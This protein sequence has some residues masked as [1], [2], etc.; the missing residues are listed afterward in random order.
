MV[1][2][3]SRRRCGTGAALLAAAETEIR[4]AGRTCTVGAGLKAG[5]PGAAW[6]AALGF[7]ETERMVM[8]VVRPGETDPALWESDTPPG[9]RI[10][11]WP[12]P[13][14]EELVDS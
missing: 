7:R 2:H 3:P 12:G 4:A 5:G 11:R 8:Q 14:P 1:V 13:A 6:A 9:Y 10:A